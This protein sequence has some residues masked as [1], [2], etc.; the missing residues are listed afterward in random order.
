VAI[1][2]FCL[3]VGVLGIVLPILPG[4]PFILVGLAILTTLSPGLQRAWHRFLRRHPRLRSRLRR[5]RS[6]EGRRSP[7]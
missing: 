7:S 3:A 1:A 4:W 2:L 5:K 6:A